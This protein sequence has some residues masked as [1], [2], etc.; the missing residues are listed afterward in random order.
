MP[1]KPYRRGVIAVFTNSAG[2]VLVGKRFGSAAAWQFPQ[3]G[4]DQG[5]TPEAALRRE[6]WEEIGC[7]SFI[8][9]RALAEPIPY[10]FPPELGGPLAAKYQGQLQYWFHC[11]LS[12]GFP[13]DLSQ[14]E[15]QEFDALAWVSPQAALSGIT[16]WKRSAYQQ[17][18]EAL[19]LL[20]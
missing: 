17:G 18:L 5:E 3:G 1:V 4:L 6:V 7:Q 15:D 11:Q 19:A 10:D 9:V 16:A 20:P 2:E 14:A 8:I 13:P 12:P